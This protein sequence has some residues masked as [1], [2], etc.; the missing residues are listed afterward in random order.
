MRTSLLLIT[1]MG[2]VMLLIGIG[3]YLAAD[4]VAS[5]MRFLL[6]LPPISV[7]A[8]IYV[9]NKVNAP[10]GPGAEEPTTIDLLKETV[11]GTL[12][13]LAITGL[14]LLGFAVL[15]ETLSRDAVRTNL[16]LITLMGGAMLIV[17]ASLYS[18]ADRVSP[19]GRYLL[20]LP[21]ISVG[22]YIYVLNKVNL[23]EPLVGAVNVFDLLLETLLGA[24]AFFVISA[25][26]L[27][28]VSLWTAATRVSRA[29]ATD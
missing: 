2:V 29:S 18:M 22:A 7:A 28:A 20:P 12:A 10:R 8:Y 11:I 24:T 23:P 21:P 4:H 27:G 9:L 17:G 19:Y 6:P 3:L 5:L 25:L 16:L 15:P 14:I 26:I 1:L 13:F